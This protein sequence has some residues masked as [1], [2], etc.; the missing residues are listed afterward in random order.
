[1][2]DNAQQPNYEGQITAVVHGFMQVW[3]K[4]EIRCEVLIHPLLRLRILPVQGEVPEIPVHEFDDIIVGKIH[5][6]HLSHSANQL[7]GLSATRF[8]WPR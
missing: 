5:D 1:M 6:N 2:T 3:N 7:P 8:V 4:F